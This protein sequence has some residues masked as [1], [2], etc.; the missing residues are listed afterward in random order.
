MKIYTSDFINREDSVSGLL[1]T[2]REASETGIGIGRAK[3]SNCRHR[4]ARAV[5]L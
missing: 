5:Q 2:K 1:V 4:K 3:E